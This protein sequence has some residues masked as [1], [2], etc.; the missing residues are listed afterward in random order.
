MP[1]MTS[2]EKGEKPH[3]CQ[4]SLPANRI[5]MVYGLSMN[6]DRIDEKTAALDT[7]RPLGLSLAENLNAWFHIELNY[8]SN[9]F[10]GSK[11]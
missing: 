9:A 4:K 6:F 5:V 1:S 11:T 2:I 8:T 3:S 10:V 7:H